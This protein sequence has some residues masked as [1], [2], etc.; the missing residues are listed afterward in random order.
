MKLHF[1]VALCVT[2]FACSPLTYQGETTTVKKRLD[3]ILINYT[4]YEDD[5]IIEVCSPYQA[6][7]SHQKLHTVIGTFSAYDVRK[8]N[9]EICIDFLIQADQEQY[10]RLTRALHLGHITMTVARESGR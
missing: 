7:T 4:L 5:G 8:V 1:F 9:N 3:S 6:V 2:L 10:Y